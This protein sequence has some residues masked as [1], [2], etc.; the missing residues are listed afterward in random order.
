MKKFFTKDY[1]IKLL[2]LFILLQPILDTYILFEDKIINIFGIS[3]STVIRLLFIL[4]AGII[5]IFI[6]KS[7]KQYIF[8]SI[9]LLLVLGYCIMHHLTA[10]NFISLIPGNFNYSMVSELFYLIRMLI[11]LA[12]IAISSNLKFKDNEFENIITVLTLM[13]SGVI[14]LTNLL[15]IS[16]GSY[17]GGEIVKFNIFTWFQN[18]HDSYT[19]Y[20]TAT[21]AYFNFANLISTLLFMLTPLL[22][23]QMFRHFNWKNIILII[24]Q[25]LATFMLGTKVATYGFI[26]SAFVML[27]VYLFFVFIKKELR[28]NSKIFITIILLLGLWFII[29]PF[30]PCNNR[31]SGTII[32]SENIQDS[33]E[34][35]KNQE[36]LS[37]SEDALDDLTEEEK[38]EY[39]R[40]FVEENYKLFYVNPDIFEKYDYKYDS[41][42]WYQMF[43]EPY[44]NQADNR[45]VVQR[46]LERL[47]TVNNNYNDTLYGITYVRM[48]NIFNLERDFVSHYYTLGIV[49]L[50]LFLAPYFIILIVCGIYILIN[51][52][53]KFTIKNT[54]LIFG[55]A[56][57]LF[58]A[59]YCGN[60]MDGLTF[61]IIL[62]FLC[63]QLI[64]QVF[65]ESKELDEKKV[66]ILALH[67]GTGGV[68]KYIASLTQM[69]ENNY[70]IE[71]I[72]TYKL[73]KNPAFKFSDNVKIK[74]LIND[75]PSK[76]EL[77]S[78][79]KNKDFKNTFVLF[80]KNLKIL[81]QKN[82]LNIKAIKNIDSKYVI[83][84]RYFHN[85]LVSK[86][87]DNRYVKIATEH[88][89][90][91]NNKKYVKQVIN[92]CFNIDYLILVSEELKN[93]YQPKLKHT[94]CIYIPNVIDKL[95]EKRIFKKHDTLISIGRLSKEKG[96]SDLVDVV[97]IIKN[98]IPNIK[99]YLIGD[100]VERE[101]IESKIKKLKLE[102][103]II[104]C[105]F[106]NSDEIEKY[107]KK[108]D[109]YVMTSFTESFGI[110]LIEAMS[111]SLPCIAFDSAN[112]AKN[113][114]S[115]N[116]GVLI[117]NRDK[118]NMANNIVKLLGDSKCLQDIGNRG[119]EYCQQ[120][121]SENVKKDW[122]DL[123]KRSGE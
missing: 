105:G 2:K 78:A 71:I 24:I 40:K 22:F 37:K 4:L 87:L 21:K 116:R 89:Y 53:T 80:F 42:F 103:N 107:M 55:I 44:E 19:F 52:K 30:S 50:I 43:K 47:K 54:S 106:C 112:G 8:Y 39:I 99:L 9:Y 82:I 59:Y 76:N 115:N 34:N 97:K 110:V 100:G 62:G 122:L 114:L 86:Y 85:K 70:K 27:L 11:P 92:S 16:T 117:S 10:S 61:T 67:L 119:Y 31:T 90:H 29:Y 88:N 104:L 118:E 57:G 60:V 113:L 46:I 120:F 35:K 69:I 33:D 15:N 14:V 102:K 26:I 94:K 23:A 81:Y 48:S 75:K 65:V 96:Y 93:Y 58:G 41:Y 20:D 5:F 1:L 111:Y 28:F 98:K 73:D 7:K 66:T 95:P 12:M 3:P 79:V 6:L 74:Y 121:L 13:T 18:I 38:N 63:G 51:Y 64:N 91:N 77:I 56:S 83:T 72:S 84:T 68:E 45:V 17:T 108:S 109:I 123:L 36:N 101:A 32:I 25:L 49:G